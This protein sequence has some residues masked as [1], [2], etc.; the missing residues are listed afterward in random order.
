MPIIQGLPGKLL[1]VRATHHHARE[2]H[3]WRRPQAR[4]LREL[5]R[6]AL[7]KR[8]DWARH[9][10]CCCPRER[11][12]TRPGSLGEG[13]TS[14]PAQNPHCWKAGTLGSLSPVPGTPGLASNCNLSLW[15]CLRQP[16]RGPHC[17]LLRKERCLGLGLMAITQWQRAHTLF[18]SHYAASPQ[19]G[20]FSSVDSSPQICTV[21]WL[22]CSHLGHT[23]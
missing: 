18:C 22:L 23:S 19:A 16:Q 9:W 13:C 7:W 3:C 6:S 21:D 10:H 4:R 11:Y 2:N 1:Q 12:P 8:A 15:G 17:L 20:H 14:S 5:W